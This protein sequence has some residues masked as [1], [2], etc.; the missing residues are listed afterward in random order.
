[1]KADERKR[2]IELR[3]LGWSVGAIAKQVKCSKSSVLR[4]VRDIPLTATQIERLESNQERGRA[5]A[6]AHP[7]SPKAVW[8]RIRR[9]TMEAATSQISLKCSPYLLKTLGS[10]LYW[11]E[12]YKAGRNMVNFSNSDPSMIKL[13]MRFFREI[14]QVPSLKFRGVVNIHPHLDREKAKKFWSRVSG[15]P[16]QQFHSV[17]LAVSKASQQKRDTLPL[18]TFRIVVC[19]T[20]LQSR[21]KGWIGGIQRWADVRANSSVG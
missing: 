20:R 12:G 15:I 17:Q 1:M 6:A 19:D 18:G 14:C 7:N 5:T 8:A 2:S 10:G 21:I 4:W 9:D 13:M 3:R 11:A 16:L